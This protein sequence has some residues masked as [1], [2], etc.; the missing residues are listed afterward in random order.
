MEMT[1]RRPHGSGA[2]HDDEQRSRAPSGW[3]R[4]RSGGR[5]AG[6]SL[7]IAV[8]GLTASSTT[9]RA[10]EVG[11]AVHGPG[12]T[13]ATFLVVLGLPVIAGL[14]GGMIAVRYYRRQRSAPPNRLSGGAIGLL[15]VGLGV[16]SLLSAIGGHPWL[17]AAGVVVGG[18]TALAS[19]IGGPVSRHGCRN[20]ADLTLGAVTI[21]RLLEGVVIGTLYA[22][23]AAV[24]LVGAVV[25]A[26][27]ATLETAAI[28]GLT[29][30]T[31]QRIFVVG[32]VG[33]V[34]VSYLVGAIAGLGVAVEVPGPAR[35]FALAVVGGALIVVGAGKTDRSITAARPA[36]A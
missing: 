7:P 4:A 8:A 13:T 3:M 29:A 12:G 19:A 33:L 34:Q 22:A 2:Q 16:S 9:A 18:A 27:H 26:G 28:G 30:G 35:T 31:Q 24:G 36:Q 10:H 23:G 6:R 25:L 21:H 17:S 14:V 11:H 32:A 15:L 5:R 20:H 1:A